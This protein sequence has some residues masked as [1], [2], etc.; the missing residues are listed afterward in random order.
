MKAS[1]TVSEVAAL[2]G[3]SVKALRLYERQGLICP[4]RTAAGWRVYDAEAIGDLQKIKVLKRLGFRLAEIRQLLRDG[5]ALTS[6]LETQQQALEDQLLRLTRAL[7]AVR[8]ARTQLAAGR[9]L[10]TD[11]LVQLVKET[12]S[13]DS[14]T[15]T[16][17]DQRLAEKHYTPEQLERITQHKT[18]PAFEEEANDVWDALLKDIEGALGESPTSARAQALAQRWLDASLAFHDGDE[19]LMRATESWYR[20]GYADPATAERMPFP[21]PIWAFAEAAVAELRR[22]HTN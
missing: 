3:L 21:K 17:A 14:F 10:S 20:E 15:W 8:E 2:T 6:L 11:D 7:A 5:I 9:A 16:D 1:L 22:T 12:H 19:T 18:A 4:A 13:M